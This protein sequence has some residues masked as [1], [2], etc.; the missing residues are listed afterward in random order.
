ML[1]SVASAALNLASELMSRIETSDP[2][3]PG[4][5]LAQRIADGCRNREG[6]AQ[7]AAGQ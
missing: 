5:Q 1:F 4:C 7:S 6:F 2:D 3:L